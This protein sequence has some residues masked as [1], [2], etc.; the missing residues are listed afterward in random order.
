[1]VFSPPTVLI[2]CL[3]RVHPVLFAA[4]TGI[5]DKNCDL[6]SADYERDVERDC[7]K[8]QRFIAL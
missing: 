4:Y 6:F 5:C 3:T 1:M 2:A 7:R 8:D